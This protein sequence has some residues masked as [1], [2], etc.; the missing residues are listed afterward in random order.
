MRIAHV[1][2][3]ASLLFLAFSLVTAVAQERQDTST[4]A[5]DQAELER[6]EKVWNEAHLHGDVAALD[7][8]WADGLVVTVPRMQVMNK[9]QSLAIWKT[10]R[11]K[12][13]RYETSDT[14]FR[15]FGDSA[16]VTGRLLRERTFG[17]K[18]IQEDWRFTKVYIRREGKW[19]VISWQ[20][21]ESAPG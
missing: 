11:M 8:L 10:G 21:S 19:Q 4:N 13:Q 17:D 3:G 16:V 15:I 14:V 2:K 6:L 7:A 5:A 1:T 9:A 12:F 18:H 20:A